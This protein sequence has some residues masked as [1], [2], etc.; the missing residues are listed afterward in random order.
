MIRRQKYD[1]QS[2][3][4][5]YFGDINL[6]GG[7]DLFDFIKNNKKLVGLLLPYSTRLHG[8]RAGTKNQL[9]K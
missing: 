1:L 2:M 6:L 9:V 4:S 7:P 3:L 5:K 8:T